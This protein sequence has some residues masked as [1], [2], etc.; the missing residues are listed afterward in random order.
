MILV[1][2][3][4]NIVRLLSFPTFLI[5][6]NIKS[7]VLLYFNCTKKIFYLQKYVKRTMLSRIKTK[8]IFFITVDVVNINMQRDYP[9]Q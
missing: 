5:T 3:L 9:G 4:D 2:I 7:F 1:F 8:I 6:T